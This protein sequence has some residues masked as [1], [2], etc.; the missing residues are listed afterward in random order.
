MAYQYQT[1][2]PSLGITQTKRKPFN[3][4]PKTEKKQEQKPTIVQNMYDDGLL[5][6]NYTNV[7]VSNVDG[8]EFI[9]R[10]NTTVG[11]KDEISAEN[12]MVGQSGVTT[13]GDDIGVNDLQDGEGGTQAD[14]E[15]TAGQRE[16]TV[17]K[18]EQQNLEVTRDILAH[19]PKKVNT[20]KYDIPE[21]ED[22][23]WSTVLAT[24]IPMLGVIAAN[25][26]PNVSQGEMMQALGITMK[27][28]A[29]TWLDYENKMKRA[30][31]VA[32]LEGNGFPPEA[33]QQWVEDGDE[34]AL[35]KARTSNPYFNKD[36][37]TVKY[38]EAGDKYQMADGSW[39]IADKTGEYEFLY[40]YDLN[41]FAQ[42]DSVSFKQTD[43]AYKFF[44]KGDVMAN[45]ETAT[46]HG[47]YS[48]HLVQDAQGNEK[49][50]YVL[51][52]PWND[53][54]ELQQGRFDAK[55]SQDAIKAAKEAG[56]NAGKVQEA[57]EA[58]KYAIFTGNKAGGDHTG[59]TDQYVPNMG[60]EAQLADG[61]FK[62]AQAMLTAEN[63]DLMKGALSD[64]DIA[65]LK[66]MS[67]ALNQGNYWDVNL[68]ELERILAKL[69]AKQ[70]GGTN[71]KTING[72]K[73]VKDA[74][75]DWYAQE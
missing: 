27:G 21:E 49:L 7:P 31:N 42:L 66:E 61:A 34:V 51:Q 14:K 15:G 52:K 63:L 60:A 43:K 45:G 74:N 11:N 54:M 71:T 65:L 39:K 35:N 73:Y 50:Q 47:Y 8:Q 59:P 25:D 32:Y 23:I 13:T 57:I 18:S 17:G 68:T 62:R 67:S 38:L 36:R 46:Q 3:Q 41:G 56:A 48:E 33:I 69:E 19:A 53:P 28:G 70:A 4:D 75:G 40:R 29:D 5:D 30:E 55:S 1:Q 22:Q 20:F 2:H 12:I 44:R 37:N 6:H 64:A 72:V 16:N 9:N 10:Y 24:A 58:V 26:N